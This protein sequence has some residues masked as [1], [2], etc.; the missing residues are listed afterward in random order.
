LQQAACL[1]VTGVVELAGEN[2]MREAESHGGNS[3]AGIRTGD[4]VKPQASV[5]AD[6]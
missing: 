3:R 6:G 4:H 1:I 5:F 2:D